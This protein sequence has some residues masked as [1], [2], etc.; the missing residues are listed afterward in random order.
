MKNK[1]LLKKYLFKNLIVIILFFL[2]FLFLNFIEYRIYQFHFN[3]K[4]VSLIEIIQEK[5]PEVNK[6]E[7][8]EILN[9]KESYHNVLQE[10]GYDIKLD[11]LIDINDQR[12][13]MVSMIKNLLFLLLFGILFWLFFHYLKRNDK[14][15]HKIVKC[16]ENINH[17]IYDLDLDESSE[18]QLSILKN[19][20]YKTTIMLKEQAENSLKD[21]LDLK[22]SLED[23]S[24]Q[25]KTPLT[26]IRIMLE[27]IMDD[28][29]MDLATREY[30]LQQIKREIMN[31]DFLVQSILKLSKLEA[32]TIQFIRQKVSVQKILEEVVQNV[33]NLCDLKNVNII[34][35]NEC[36]KEINCDIRWQVEALTNILK[37]AVEYSKPGDKVMIE[38]EDNNLYVQIKIIDFGKG[39]NHQDTLNIFKRFYKGKGAKEDSVG[40]GL[41]LAK[42]MIENDNGRITVESK[43]GKGTTFK[44]KYFFE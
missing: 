20:I 34:V 12:R 33:S 5:Y 16:V 14:E 1:E 30:F 3:E 37:N 19:E 21:K 28:P 2:L 31:I 40:I 35:K 42:T 23:I 44:I 6:E 27:N 36:K 18:D 29:E 26:S 15:I 24:H 17:Q 32:N 22:K 10:Y 41:T 13:Q 38:C 25:L 8:I 39:M 11:S 7:M 4:I 43:E 9:A